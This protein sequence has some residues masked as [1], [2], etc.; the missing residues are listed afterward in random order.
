MLIPHYLLGA[1]LIHVVLISVGKI[2]IDTIPGMTQEISW[3]TV[4][5][6]YLA[7]RDFQIVCLFGIT[8][9]PRISFPT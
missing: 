2:I 9:L 5:L 3:T 8:N 6:A 1:W 4:N 7:V